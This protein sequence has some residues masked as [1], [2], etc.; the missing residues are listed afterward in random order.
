[1]DNA[2]VFKYLVTNKAFPDLEIKDH[3]F[4]FR[5]VFRQSGSTYD[6]GIYAIICFIRT[7]RL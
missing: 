6:T 7:K 2:D 4:K 3:E 5:T 1:M